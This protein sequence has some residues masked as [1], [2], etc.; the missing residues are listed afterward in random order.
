[1]RGFIFSYGTMWSGDVVGGGG[2][3]TITLPGRNTAV[4]LFASQSKNPLS[5]FPNGNGIEN[6]NIYAWVIKI[7]TLSSKKL[8][9]AWSHFIENIPYLFLV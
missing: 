3:R 6:P 4:I 9:R 7:K 5:S 8:K 2:V 1:M